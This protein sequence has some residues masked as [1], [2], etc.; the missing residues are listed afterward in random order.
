MIEIDLTQ[1]KKLSLWAA[2]ENHHSHVKAL[3][4]GQQM[5]KLNIILLQDK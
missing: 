5:E 3:Y 4:Q 1:F 2:T